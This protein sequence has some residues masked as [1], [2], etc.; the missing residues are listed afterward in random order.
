MEI[1]NK[2]TS[3]SIF[4]LSYPLKPQNRKMLAEVVFGTPNKECQG[5]GI[6]KVIA[7]SQHFNCKTCKHATATIL[8]M[9]DHIL[10]FIFE[11][12]A[13]STEIYNRFFKE[14]AFKVYEKFVLPMWMNTY[15]GLENAYIKSGKYMIIKQ[16]TTITIPLSIVQKRNFPTP[17][18][19][20]KALHNSETSE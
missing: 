19:P 14:E 4:P 11:D 10:L 7:F 8:H 6:C 16:E 18:L 15:F 17:M 12:L 2:Y 5:Y 1:V 13:I 3:P 9:N 20:T